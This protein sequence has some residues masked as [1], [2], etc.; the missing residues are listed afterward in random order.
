MKLALIELDVVLCDNSARMAEAEAS[1]FPSKGEGADRYWEIAE[2][3]EKVAADLPVE[4]VVEAVEELEREGWTVVFMSSRL[5]SRLWAVT[6]SWLEWH[7]LLDYSRRDVVLKPG[8]L[9]MMKTTTWKGSMARSF[10]KG[11]WREGDELLLVDG[12]PE[13]LEAMVKEVSYSRARIVTATS[14]Q[15]ALAK[16]NS[17]EEVIELEDIS[18]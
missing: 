14:L 3:V 8:A 16:V 13:N 17:R 15:E 18:F 6:V 10:V 2:Q 1:G 4:G 12:R 5:S 9:R 11:C 7:G